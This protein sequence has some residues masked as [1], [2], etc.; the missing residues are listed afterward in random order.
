MSKI[1]KIEPTNTSRWPYNLR[2]GLEATD[3]MRAWLIEAFGHGDVYNDET[4]QSWYSSATDEP[5]EYEDIV[6]FLWGP[7]YIQFKHEEDMIAFVLR[8]SG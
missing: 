3:E 8:F 7:G 1:E 4:T 5:D 2:I 6:Y